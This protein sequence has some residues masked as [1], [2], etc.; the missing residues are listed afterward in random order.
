MKF[1]S[2]FLSLVILH[3]DATESPSTFPSLSPS[4]VPSLP[5]SGMPTTFPTLAP[6][7]M[8][9]LPPSTMPSVSARPSGSPSDSPSNSPTKFGTSIDTVV[10]DI[11][12]KLDEIIGNKN[13]R[14]KLKKKK[15][16]VKKAKK[17]LHQIKN[18][19]YHCG[20]IAWGA[21]GC[22]AMNCL[23]VDNLPIALDPDGKIEEICE[24][25]QKDLILRM[26][27]EFCI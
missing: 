4:A 20:A 3:A 11:I 26:A 9:S 12:D 8:P 21:D 27:K 5:P 18:T 1:F 23:N 2:L 24:E 22:N 7:G 14:K 25:I 19:L 15:V 10:D 13:R 6:S 17:Y 16:N